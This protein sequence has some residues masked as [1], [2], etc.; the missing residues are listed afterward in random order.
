MELP[1]VFNLRQLRVCGAP[2]ETCRYAKCFQIF[3]FSRKKLILGVDKRILLLYNICVA[4][5]RA[6]CE[7]GGTG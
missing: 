7:S 5:I 2:G 6:A 3:Q 1:Q 4:R